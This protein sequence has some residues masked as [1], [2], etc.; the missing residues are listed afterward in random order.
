[1]IL[2]NSKGYINMA[3]GGNAT[4]TYQLINTDAHERAHLVTS[5]E[6]IASSVGSSA[7]LAWKLSNWIQGDSVNTGGGMTQ[8]N[9]NSQYNNQS[10]GLLA[11]GSGMAS[12]VQNRDK[13]YL[14]VFV[15]GTGSSPE[16][17]DKNFIKS[18]G[19]TFNEKVE[20]LRWSGGNTKEARTEGAEGLAK[21]VENHKFKEGEK[22]NIVGHSHGGNV[23]KEFTQM[24]DGEKKV[25]NMVFLGTPHRKDYSL[26][27]SD[28]SPNANKVNLYDKGDMVQ[29]FAGIVLTELYQ[30]MKYTIDDKG[31]KYNTGS[32]DYWKDSGQDIRE[33][34]NASNGIIT[35]AFQSKADLDNFNDS[36]FNKKDE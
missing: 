23:M 30:G 15:H 9:W 10:S 35:P 2:Q 29:V 18:V 17:A 32:L 16:D 27:Y 7:E 24:Y 34:I 3:N 1:M 12:K 5:N 28:L 6:N 11:G 14:T 33:A 20:Q 13:D 4:D 26:D 8:S 19:D 31:G 36:L 25:D 21:M 22:L